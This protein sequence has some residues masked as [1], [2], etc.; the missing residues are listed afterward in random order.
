M[1]QHVEDPDSAV[2]EMAR[3]LRL[4]GRLALLEP[5]WGTLIVNGGNP[6]VTKQILIAHVGRHPQPALGRKLRGLLTTHGFIDVEVGAGV[7]TYTD[8]A[9][10]FRAFGMFRAAEHAV[11]TGAA[12]EDEALKWSQD[13]TKADDDLTF[14]ASVT[15]FRAVGRLPTA[16]HR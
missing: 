13:L 10:A 6:A 7:S 11:T 12:S 4:G 8:L 9:S 1:L 16:S 3:A 14:F 5:D 15:G 2:A